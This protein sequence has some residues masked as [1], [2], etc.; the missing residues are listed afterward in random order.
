M[1]GPRPAATT[2]SIQPTRPT[3][4]A[5]DRPPTE[6]RGR[7]IWFVN[8][9]AGSPEHGM[10]FRHYELGQALA[11]RGHTVAVISG[12]YSHLFS[13]PPETHATYAFETL[14]RVAYCWVRVPPYGRAVSLGRV[15]NMFAFMARLYR[16]PVRRLPAPDAIVV[17]SPS[18][19]PIL[20]AE[21]WARRFGAALVFEVRDLWPLTLQE[22]GGTSRWHPLVL[23]MSWF[24]RHACRVADAVVS[25]LPAAGEHLASRGMAPGKLTVIPNG[26]SPD[27]L[28][29]ATGATPHEVEAAVGRRPFNVGFVG[30]LGSANALENLLGAARLL[31]DDGDI[32]VVIVGHGSEDERLRAMAADLDDVTFTGPVAK[33][34]V[35]ATLAAFDACYVGYHRTPLYRFGIAPNKV[36][37]YMAAAMPIVLAADAANDP[38]REA[39]CGMTVAPDDPVALAGAIRRLRDLS[40]TERAELGARGR[41]YVERVHAYPRLAE[42]YEAVLDRIAP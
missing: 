18:L 32:G 10:E 28:T 5:T 24:E 29:V 23:L 26:A 39:G 33:R 20:P 17:S 8:Q 27:A 6:G 13:R 41:V 1:A 31:V 2:R 19:F 34:D 11:A 9:Y 7:V 16:L 30:T 36:L 14:D 15:L 22:L 3:T 25:V 40:A 42:R 4:D 12:T 35:P 38:V 21:R 37:D